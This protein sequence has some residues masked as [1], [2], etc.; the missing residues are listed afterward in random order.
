MIAESQAKRYFVIVERLFASCKDIFGLGWDFISLSVLIKN[1]EVT[2]YVIDAEKA[3]SQNDFKT[4][5][6]FLIMAFETAKS[7]RQISQAGSLIT[8]DKSLASSAVSQYPSV[9]SIENGFRV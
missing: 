3:F 7:I 2:K 8:I 4:C 1:N 5:A 9:G 6:K